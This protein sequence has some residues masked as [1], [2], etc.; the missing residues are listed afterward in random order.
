[1]PAEIQASLY[2][3]G[4]GT[5]N[6]ALGNAANAAKKPGFWDTFGPALVGG[7]GAVGAGFAGK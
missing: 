3:T 6:G 7:A 1:V 5:A 2:G 4:T